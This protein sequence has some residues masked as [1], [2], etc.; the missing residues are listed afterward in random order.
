M[1]NLIF[2]IFAFLAVFSCRSEDDTDVSP[3]VGEWEWVSSTGGVGNT[4]E[5]PASSGKTII[6]KLDS[7]KKYTITTN[8]TV[9]NEGTFSLYKNVSNLEHYERVY[10]DF[11]NASDQMIVN[12][13]EKTL[14]VSASIGVSFYPLD[15]NDA[16][17]LIENADQAMYI[18]KQTGKNRFCFFKNIP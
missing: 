13:E 5:T 10:I 7:D 14:H 1:K 15:T 4:T 11:S 2:A 18:A 3:V 16:D 17:R 9:T 12:I 6:M 8:G